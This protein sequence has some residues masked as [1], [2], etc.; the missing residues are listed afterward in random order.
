M[1]CELSPED[2]HRWRESGKRF[3]LLDVRDPDECAIA[4]L[5]GS[6]NIPMADVARRAA[7]LPTDRPIVVLCHH[8]LR[9]ARVAAMLSARGFG[10]VYSVDGGI[11]AYRLRVDPTLTAY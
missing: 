3:E 1:V 2:L 9:S 5:K 8:G 10:D 7:E 6:R 11:D 4:S